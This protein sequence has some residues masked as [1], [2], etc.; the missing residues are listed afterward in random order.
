MKKSSLVLTFMICFIAVFAQE[1]QKVQENKN[2]PVLTFDK[3]FIVDNDI[4]YDYGKIAKGSDGVCYFV[5]TNTGKEPLLVEKT[6]ACCGA[7]TKAP[8][9]PVL[10]GQKDS[11]SVKYN[12]SRALIIDKAI[13]VYS[14][15]ANDPVTIKVKGEVVE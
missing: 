4:I 8:E 5:F 7:T 2:A 6:S 9:N 12:T 14:N 15:A 13:T 11:I 1:E 3:Q 10:P